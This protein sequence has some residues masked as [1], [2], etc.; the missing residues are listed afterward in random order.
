MLWWVCIL[1]ARKPVGNASSP[2]QAPS[3][4]AGS[5]CNRGRT[6]PSA[7]ARLSSCLPAKDCTGMPLA[8][9]AVEHVPRACGDAGKWNLLTSARIS[10][11]LLRSVADRGD[12]PHCVAQCV[13]SWGGC[14]GWGGSW[15]QKGITR[16]LVQ[17]L[18]TAAFHPEPHWS[19]LSA[20]PQENAAWGRLAA[21]LPAT[22]PFPFSAAKVLPAHI[23][24]Y[25][26]IL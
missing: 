18:L 23:P 11:A 25:R 16:T 19:W 3:G 2:P 17:T 6:Q 7:S 22:L 24:K 14:L 5:G 9:A 8:V 15:G 26:F 1:C 4:S 21:G 12:H 13:H 10:H 20:L